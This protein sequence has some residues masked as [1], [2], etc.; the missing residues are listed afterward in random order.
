V[1]I[2]LVAIIA[3]HVDCF[4]PKGLTHIVLTKPRPCHVNKCFILPLNKA[5]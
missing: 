2:E 1:T 4:N 5:I 3:S